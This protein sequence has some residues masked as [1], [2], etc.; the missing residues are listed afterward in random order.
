MIR[1]DIFAYKSS[2]KHLPSNKILSPKYINQ[3]NPSTATVTESLQNPIK[4]CNRVTPAPCDRLA[5]I[6]LI[7]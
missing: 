6:Y 5:I 7:V 2:N 1:L 4:T 3:S